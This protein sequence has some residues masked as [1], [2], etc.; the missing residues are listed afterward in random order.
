M[1]MRMSY[2]E[3]ITLTTSRVPS[4]LW[5]FSWS[6]IFGPYVLLRIRHIND[7]HYWAWQTRLALIAW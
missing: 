1:V 4:I 3:L 5:Q 7:T 6:I 2:Y